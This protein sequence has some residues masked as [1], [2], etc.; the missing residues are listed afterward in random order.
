[1]KKAKKKRS[2]RVIVPVVLPDNCSLYY[3]SHGFDF[4]LQSLR[5]CLGGIVACGVLHLFCSDTVD[6]VI[7]P[8]IFAILLIAPALCG[9][10]WWIEAMYQKRH[11]RPIVGLTEHEFYLQDGLG[12]YFPLNQITEIKYRFGQLRKR[13]RY[14]AI[15][16]CTKDG[17]PVEVVLPSL[18]LIMDLRK[19]LPTVKWAVSWISHL[20]LCLLI[21][22]SVGGILSLILLMK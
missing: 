7:L 16:L 9:A 11:G 12:A 19:A 2:Q 6:P 8:L 14:A 20:I 17:K 1:M 5:M 3:T 15:L 4:F 18:R 13:G 10:G 21:G 22:L